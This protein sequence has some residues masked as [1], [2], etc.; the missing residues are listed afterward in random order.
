MFQHL[1]DLIAYGSKVQNPKKKGK[2]HTN[3]HRD[4]VSHI[5]TAYS[6]FV[7]FA[8]ASTDRQRGDGNK[9]RTQANGDDDDD[10]RQLNSSPKGLPLATLQLN[11]LQQSARGPSFSLRYNSQIKTGHGHARLCTSFAL[12]HA[13]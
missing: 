5:H 1:N 12:A 7:I 2:Q 9:W 11:E 10:A 8:G 13:Q 3:T 4:G 6:H